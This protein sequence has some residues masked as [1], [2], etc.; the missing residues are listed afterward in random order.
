M[1]SVPR[2]IVVLVTFMAL[3][4]STVAAPAEAAVPPT[5]QQSTYAAQIAELLDLHNEV[6]AR[7]GLKAL[8]YSPTLA[9]KYTQPYADQLAASGDFEHNDMGLL[10]QWPGTNSAGEN[11]YMGTGT[12]ATPQAAIDGWMNSQGH[13]DNILKADWEYLAIGWGVSPDGALYA[14]VNFWRG[15]LT[16]LGETYST[17]AQLRT[18]LT[19]TTTPVDV[20][21]YTTPGLHTVNGRDWRTECEPYSP[22][23]TRCRAEIWAT[24]VTYSNGRFSQTNKW[25]F[26]NLAY[27]PSPRAPWGSNPLANDRS[28]S[29]GGRQWETSCGDSWTGPKACRSFIYATV[30]ESWIDSTGTRRYRNKPGTKVFNN[31]VYFR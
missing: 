11:L 15:A 25:A 9:V 19:G 2:A 6:R 4:L 29:Q 18:A 5:Q 1:Q 27:L 12:L 14:S 21:V 17:G 26:N 22:T 31:V 7:H 3:L 30:I 16:G 20:N 28:W 24:V 23:V 13:R 8:R 10:M